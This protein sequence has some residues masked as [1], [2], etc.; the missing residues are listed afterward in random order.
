[1]HWPARIQ[2]GRITDQF[3]YV[4]DFLPTVL[5]IAG[6]ALPGD[7]YRGKALHRPTGTSLLP[8]LEG[9]ADAVHEPTQVTGF[10][11]TGGFAIFRGDFK[12]VRDGPPFSDGAWHLYNLR[13]DPTESRDLA[14]SEPALFNELKAEVDKFIAANGVVLPEPGYNGIRQVLTN[15]API[16]LRQMWPILAGALLMVGLL[17]YA[18]VAWLLRARRRR[19]AGRGQ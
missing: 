15:N 4:T 17:L 2:G 16:L 9:K 10:E 13:Q 7:E 1:M 12:L 11:S 6:I 14:T 8:Y 3:A 5:D 18:V 19:A